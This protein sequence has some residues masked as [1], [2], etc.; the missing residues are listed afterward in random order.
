MKRKLLLV[1]I[2]PC[3]LLAAQAQTNRLVVPPELESS[4]G[5]VSGLNPFINTPRSEQIYASRRVFCSAFGHNR[6][7]RR[8]LSTGRE[9]TKLEPY[10]S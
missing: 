4:F 6:D 10:D 9:R 2:V 5:G 8:R 1:L 7:N 3:A